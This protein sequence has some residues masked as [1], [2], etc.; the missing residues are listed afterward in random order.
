MKDE[1]QAIT[2]HQL[3]KLGWWL[4]EE[5]GCLVGVRPNPSGEYFVSDSV[6]VIWINPNHEIVSGFHSALHNFLLKYPALDVE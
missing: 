1:V 2:E 6:H 4:D 5:S 3:L